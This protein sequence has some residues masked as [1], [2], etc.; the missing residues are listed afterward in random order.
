MEQRDKE[1]RG[2]CGGGDDE[3]KRSPGRTAVEE[4]SALGDDNVG[5]DGVG[6]ESDKAK[7]RRW[8][9]A[10]GA[11]AITLNVKVQW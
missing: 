11:K 9:I 6:D 2:D 4:Y 10:A 7:L 8:G 3:A 1:Y 5:D